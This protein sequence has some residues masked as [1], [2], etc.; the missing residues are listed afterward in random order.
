MALNAVMGLG[1]I[2]NIT[3]V[4]YIINEKH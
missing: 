4:K 1:M 3:N 2:L